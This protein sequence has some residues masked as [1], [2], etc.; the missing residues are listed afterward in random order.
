MTECERETFNPVLQASATTDE[1]DAPS[2]LN[3]ELRAPQFE[4]FSASPSELRS[5]IVTMPPGFTINPDAA[6]GQSACTDAQANFGSEGPANCP[7]NSKIG[8]F[9][10]GSPTLSGPLTGAIYIGEPQAR[11]PVP[12]V[13]G[14][15]GLRHE[16]QARRLVSSRPADRAAD[17]L[18]RRSATASLRNF[19]AASVCFRQGA[20]GDAR[21]PARSTPSAPTCS[22]GTRRWPIRPRPR[23]SASNSGP[24]GSQCP[25]QIRPFEPSLVGRHLQ[26]HGRRLLLLHA[27][28][29]PRRRRPVPGQAQLH[30]APRPDRQ[31]ARHHLLPGGRDRRSGA[32]PWAK[33]SRPTRAARPRAKSAPPT[34]PP[35][36]AR[37][38][39]TPSARSTWPAP[40][41]ARR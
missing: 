33:S 28:A 24:H 6:D 7:D 9:S 40:S 11:Q 34:S 13:H 35:A 37:T 22:P 38:P 41:R 19:P 2:G 3:I 25:G 18:I 1:T 30:D 36:P 27:E 20:D 39:S 29:R 5:A 16:H 32:T 23:S 15:L 8:T 17:H 12:P 31:S 26:P 14:R 10:I 4:G 21:P